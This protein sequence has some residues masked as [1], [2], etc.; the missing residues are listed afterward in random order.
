MGSAENFIIGGPT[1]ALTY[2]LADKG[3]DVWLC[4]ARG[5]WHSRKHRTLNPDTEPKFWRFSWHEIA[6]YDLPVTI[7]YIL[8]VTD[9]SKLHF[10]GH[11]QGTTTFFAMMS[12]K[13]E[14]NEKVR[15]MI[16]MAPSALLGHI[17]DPTIRL[18][19]PAYRYL[20]VMVNQIG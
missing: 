11:S 2:V 17:K 19:A 8:N 15:V 6:Y 16:A 9:T 10:I 7:D 12:E 20:Q 5:T 18:V 14:Y 13:P 4:N 1:K 3:Y